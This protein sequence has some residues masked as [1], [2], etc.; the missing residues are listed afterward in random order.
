MVTGKGDE[1][2]G[3]CVTGIFFFWNLLSRD[4]VKFKNSSVS[5]ELKEENEVG[6]N[7]HLTH[8]KKGNKRVDNR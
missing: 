2:Q 6:L 7:E 1:N 3:P 5:L 8:Q 4:H